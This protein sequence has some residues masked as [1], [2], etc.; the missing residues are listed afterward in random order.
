MLSFKEFI[1]LLEPDG[2]IVTRDGT[3]FET[4]DESRRYTVKD[5]SYRIDKV[6]HGGGGQTHAHV[7]CRRNNQLGVINFDGS[8]SHSSK[9]RLPKAVAAELEKKGFA[10]RTDRMVEW[11]ALDQDSPML[12]G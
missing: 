11:L 12:F 5:G 1:E 3:H 8:A 10:I 6:L 4:L 2:V 9:F 7:F